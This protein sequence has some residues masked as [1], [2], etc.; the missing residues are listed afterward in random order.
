MKS[1][2][3]ILGG[4]LQLINGNI[5]DFID[6]LYYGDELWFTY[7]NVK[8]MIQGYL[9]DETYNLYLLMPYSEGKGYSWICKGTKDSY[10]VNDF[11]NAPIFDGKSF[12]EV[13]QN[14]EWVDC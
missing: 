13:E 4:C 11:L 14:I 3:N 10:P 1:T 12:M 9:E 6:K 2:K 7:N 5:K 8:Y